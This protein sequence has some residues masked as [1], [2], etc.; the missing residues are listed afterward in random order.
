MS[1]KLVHGLL[2][3]LATVVQVANLASGVVPVHYQ[4]LVAALVSVAQ[5]T[6]ALYNHGASNGSQSSVQGQS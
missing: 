3:G 1:S 6:L 5:A 4:P 2:Q